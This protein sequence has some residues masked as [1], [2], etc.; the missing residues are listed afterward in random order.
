MAIMLMCFMCVSP[1]VSWIFR[2]LVFYLLHC[3]LFLLASLF[4]VFLLAGLFLITSL[5]HDSSCF[6][7]ACFCFFQ[8]LLFLLASL[9]HAF[10]LASLSPASACIT[11]SSLSMLALLS[12]V[13]VLASL[14]SF[15]V[16]PSLSSVSVLVSL[17][18]VS[19]LASLAPV[20]VL[21]SLSSVSFGTSVFACL[22]TVLPSLPPVYLQPSNLQVL[23]LFVSFSAFAC[24]II[25][26][27][28]SVLPP[29]C[30]HICPYVYP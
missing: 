28:V 23:Y 10:L 13:F 6:C 30:P 2:C 22:S 24:K 4:P 15:S 1:R 3:H 26:L 14:S 8:Y 20:S 27:F 21:A 19:V 12:S 29:M 9:S 16:H 11:V 18:S 25:H 17:T 7:I 5:S